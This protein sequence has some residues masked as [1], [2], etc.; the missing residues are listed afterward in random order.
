[1]PK[2]CSRGGHN[3]EAADIGTGSDT[4]ATGICVT[5]PGMDTSTKLV[6]HSGAIPMPPGAQLGLRVLPEQVLVCT[7]SVRMPG[8][9][10]AS[11][12][13]WPGCAVSATTTQPSFRASR[14]H[15]VGAALVRTQPVAHAATDI[16]GRARWTSVSA[17]GSNSSV[18]KRSIR[19]CLPT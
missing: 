9:P 15:V 13:C 7:E 12:R 5:A 14:A 6:K 4:A 2:W 18:S 3:G 1:M 19:R 11:L 17:G 16:S 8:V 10:R